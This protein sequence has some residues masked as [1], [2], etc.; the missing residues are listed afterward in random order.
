[1]LEKEVN[2]VLGMPDNVETF[3]LIPISYPIGKYGPVA[4][5]PVEAVTFQDRWEKKLGA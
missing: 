3:A 4:R 1:M 5:L 2:E